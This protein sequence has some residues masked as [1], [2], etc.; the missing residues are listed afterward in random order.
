MSQQLEQTWEE[1]VFARG[2]ARGKEVGEVMGALRNA[3]DAVRDVLA[4]RFGEL[5]AGV[6]QRIEVADDLARLRAAL[7]QALHVQSPEELQL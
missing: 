4:E 6:V 7:R 2:E 3:R 1:E 5:P